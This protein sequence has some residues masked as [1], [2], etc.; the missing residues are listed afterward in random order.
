MTFEEESL[1]FGLQFEYGKRKCAGC[2]QFRK[3]LYVVNYQENNPYPP[4][5]LSFCVKCAKAPALVFAEKVKMAAK[6][7]D[8]YMLAVEL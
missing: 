3:G 6:N 4:S 7:E 8:A 5:R 2:G 1:A